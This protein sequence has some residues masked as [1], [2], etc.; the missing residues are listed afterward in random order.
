ML[1][2]EIVETAL[3]IIFLVLCVAAS[4][5]AYKKALRATARNARKH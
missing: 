5:S 3:P 1:I 2:R 4:L